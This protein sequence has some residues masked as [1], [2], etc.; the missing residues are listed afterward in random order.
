MSYLL[1][2]GLLLAALGSCLLFPGGGSRV[3]SGADDVAGDW[4]LYSFWDLLARNDPGWDRGALSIGDDGAVAG[5]SVR[6][7]EGATVQIS[8]GQ[9]SIDD[10]GLVSGT[11]AY[12]D[13]SESLEEFTLDS[14]ETMIVGAHTD[15]EQYLTMT[16]VLRGGAMFGSQDMEGTWHLYSFWGDQ[17]FSDAGWDRETLTIDAAGSVLGGDLMDSYGDG[18]EVSD[19]SLSIDEAG[20][21]SGSIQYMYEDGEI[22]V[23]PLEKFQLDPGKTLMV[24][25]DTD[26]EGY[27][28]ITVG[29]KG[30]GGF[31]MAHLEG[32]WRLYSLSDRPSR[33]DPRW[34][35]GTVVLDS[36]GA[37]TGGNIVHSDGSSEA[38][39]GGNVTTDESGFVS[40][41]VR[42][43][44]S[45]DHSLS[46]FKMDPDKSTI[47]GVLTDR[48]GREVLLMLVRKRI[49]ETE[50]KF[51]RGDVDA[52]GGINITDAVFLLDFLF[53]GGPRPP[54][55]DAADADD[56]GDD[57]LNLTDPITILNWL[58]LA[59]PAPGD[60]GPTTADYDPRDCGPDP[61]GDEDGIECEE[62]TPCL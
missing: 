28:F 6:D 40:G 2:R 16:V 61:S 32:T 17:E 4:R 12:A 18:A 30:G 35:R 39:S 33:N 51:V 37:I 43:E 62:F 38:V 58:F 8:G 14:G 13:R 46:R 26:D 25:V 50:T 19:G 11:I 27:R 54:C 34:T 31:E 1:F 53:L 23:A 41:R 49:R 57:R 10:A 5:G 45:D 20:F 29:V 44:G 52:S 42:Y 56:E 55:M 47:V 59:G 36:S 7:S 48:R 3:A 9:V 60:P 24:G 15:G 22:F 21:V